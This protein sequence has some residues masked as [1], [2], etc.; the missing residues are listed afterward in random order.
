[1][2]QRVQNY[3]GCSNTFGRV[4]FIYIIKTRLLS[5]CL[6][7]HQ[8]IGAKKHTYNLNRD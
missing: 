1:M 4:E 7:D 8:K 2:V 6:F 5:V 3:G